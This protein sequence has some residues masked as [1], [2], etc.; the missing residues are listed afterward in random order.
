[1]EKEDGIHGMLPCGQMPLHVQKFRAVYERKPNAPI[2]HTEGWYYCLDAWREQGLPKNLEPGTDEWNEFFHFD[3]EAKHIIRGLGWVQAEYHPQFEENVIEVRNDGTELIQD[4]AGRK[5]LMFKGR[6]S[7]FMPE[8]VD[9][10][11]KDRQSWEELIQWR[12]DFNNQDRQADLAKA[13]QEMIAKAKRGY[14]MQQRAIGAYMYLRSLIGPE[15]LLYMF[16]DDPDLIHAC[17][18]KWFDLSDAVIAETQKHV[19]LDEIF[20][21]E[22]ICYKSGPLISPA[23][24]EE[25]LMPHYSK[26]VKNAR[27]RQIDQQRPLHIQI[28]TDGQCMPVIPLYKKYLEMD[29]M[30]PFEAASGCDVLQIG[31]DYPNLIMIHGIDKRILAKS[32]EA[33]DTELERIIPP[34]KKRGGYIPACDHGVPEEVSLENYLHYPEKNGRTGWISDSSGKPREKT[35]KIK[36]I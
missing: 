26:L 20:F 9:H 18:Q 21:G 13:V 29:V 1:M 16:Y 31:R 3:P 10:P 11:V 12:L 14:F 28:D 24:I 23:M 35:W 15:G 36:S 30:S 2:Y 5:V 34:L 33:I 27:R 19:S 17:L 25:F 8:Y 7:G 6:R 32:K 22:D 4:F